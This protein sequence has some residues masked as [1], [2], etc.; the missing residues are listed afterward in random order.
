VF[1]SAARYEPFG[2]AV[3]EAAMHG[4]ALVLADITTFRELWH[5][6]ALFVPA[7]DAAGFAAAFDRLA[8]ELPLRR[9]LAARAGERARQFTPGRQVGQVQQA[10]AAA[11]AT[12]AQLAAE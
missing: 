9:H 1:A 12:H 6:A 8:A 5:D 3:L 4:A 2:L 11:L 10:Y 7:D